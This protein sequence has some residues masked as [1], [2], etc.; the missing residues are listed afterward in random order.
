M[1]LELRDRVETRH[2]ARR[3]RLAAVLIRR[4]G[5]AETTPEE[6]RQRRAFVQSM[7][8]RNPEAFSCGEDVTGMMAH[9]PGRF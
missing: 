4:R 3:I 6:A 8:S 7:L 9:F 2:H 5:D 1:H